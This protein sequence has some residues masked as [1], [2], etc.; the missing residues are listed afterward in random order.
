MIELVI[1]AAVVF[2]GSTSAYIGYVYGLGKGKNY[3]PPGYAKCKHMHRILTAGLERRL[4]ELPED[5]LWKP[6]PS[7]KENE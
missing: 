7:P 4:C 5:Q 3:R 6:K 1:V 2:V